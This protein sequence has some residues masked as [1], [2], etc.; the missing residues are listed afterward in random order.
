MGR[1]LQKSM[2]TQ[3]I[4]V[5][6]SRGKVWGGGMSPSNWGWVWKGLSLSRKFLNFVSRNGVFWCIMAQYCQTVSEGPCLK[7]FTP[8]YRTT[9]QCNPPHSLLTL[10]N[11]QYPQS[12][13]CVALRHVVLRYP[14]WMK[15][16]GLSVDLY[17]TL[18]W[19]ISKALQ[20]WHVLT[21]DHSF[22]CHPHVYP[23][24]EWAIPAF[25]PEPQSI[26]ALWLVLISRRLSWPGWLGEILR[27]F[28]RRRQS[29]NPVLTGPDVE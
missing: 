14:V 15:Y 18:S 3:G 6:A 13:R 17:S 11:W 5:Q 20:V 7:L 16:V 4:E 23:Q 27:W 1:L 12:M 25:K 9:M 10:S 2:G 26:T 21:R 8:D 19:F 22:T 28:V 29:P 24:I